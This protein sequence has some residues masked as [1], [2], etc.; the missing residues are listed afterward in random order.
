[1]PHFR[2]AES[3]AQHYSSV[4]SRAFIKES[5]ESA[6]SLPERAIS[7]HPNLVT[8][9]GLRK[10]EG[11]VRELETAREAARQDPD[12]S[13]LA[14]IERDL[15]YWN[16]RRA[17]ARVV[18][19]PAT[20]DR[21]RFGVRVKLHLKDGREFTFRLVGEDEADPAA[22]L[23]SWVSPVADALMNQAVGDEVELMGQR[24]E[25]VALD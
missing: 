21:V 5:D 2:V 7:P 11:Q 6:Q 16:Q 20:L 9:D 3:R 15:R 4:M 1:M 8:A 22:G 19:P 18:A 17:T 14:R 13:V 12:T 23:L 25:I 24:A 10:I